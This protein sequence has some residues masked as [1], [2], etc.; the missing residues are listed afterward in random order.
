VIVHGT[1]TGD[2][3]ASARLELHATSRIEGD[4]TAGSLVVQE[5]AVLNGRC[6]MGTA[7]KADARPK[8][9]VASVPVDTTT[10]AKQASNKAS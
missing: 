8:I 10:P 9:E 4:V 2:I 3:Q 1:V 6:T 5:G 7:G